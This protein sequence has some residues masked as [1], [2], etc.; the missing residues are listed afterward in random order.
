MAAEALEVKGGMSGMSWETNLLQML[1]QALFG[2]AC[3]LDS[4]LEGQVD[5][6][7]LPLDVLPGL[8]CDAVYHAAEGGGGIALALGA[9]DILVGE[10]CPLLRGHGAV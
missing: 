1:L 7:P 6:G 10:G 9:Q 3:L 4:L 5:R 8:V 2:L